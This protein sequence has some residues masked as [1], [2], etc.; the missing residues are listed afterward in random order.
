MKL[1]DYTIGDRVHTYEKVFRTTSKEGQ[2][3]GVDII[4]IV[5]YKEKKPELLMIVEFRPPV[6]GFT[7]EFPTGMTNDDNY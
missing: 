1:V 3:D 2:I 5:R 6:H 7:L 4:P